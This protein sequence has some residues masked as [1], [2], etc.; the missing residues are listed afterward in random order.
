VEKVENAEVLELGGVKSRSSG[1]VLM[2]KVNALLSFDV[3]DNSTDENEYVLLL[4][5]IFFK[6]KF[7]SFLINFL[8]KSPLG[9]TTF[10]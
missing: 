3:N 1:I 4:V 2:L 5:I 10:C 6:C 8:A 9:E 7:F